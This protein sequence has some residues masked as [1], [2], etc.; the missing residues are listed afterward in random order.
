MNLWERKFVSTGI[1]TSGRPSGY[2][3]TGFKKVSW[4]VTRQE[5]FNRDDR[6]KGNVIPERN[7]S[8]INNVTASGI[9]IM[10]SVQPLALFIVS[11]CISSW[12]CASS[13]LFQRFSAFYIT[14]HWTVRLAIKSGNKAQRIISK[15][16]ICDFA[17]LI[18]GYVHF[19]QIP[20]GC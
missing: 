8:S 2:K 19:M 18:Y 6:F 11:E 13:R 5:D 1:L 3:A 12:L 4:H 20:T 17:Y 14:S 16:V 15:Y 9:I 7:N 10:I